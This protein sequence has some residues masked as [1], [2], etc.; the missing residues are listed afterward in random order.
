MSLN[1]LMYFKY[2][3]L[4]YN[5]ILIINSDCLIT[6]RSMDIQIFFKQKTSV[7]YGHVKFVKISNSCLIDK[8][9][10]K[11]NLRHYWFIFSLSR[12]QLKNDELIYLVGYHGNC[13]IST[14]IKWW[15]L[16]STN[17]TKIMNI[18]SIIHSCWNPTS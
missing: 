8:F 7:W 1:C 6:S 9:K 17:F 10:M 2:N 13:S 11:L 12:F 15:S 4:V 16:I 5:D 14:T 18:L 3:L